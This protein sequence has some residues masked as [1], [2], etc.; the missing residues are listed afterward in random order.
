MI[1]TYKSLSF[2]K[3][4]GGT[5]MHFPRRVFMDIDVGVVIKVLD[6]VDPRLYFSVFEDG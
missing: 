6:L 1:Q 3:I 2:P 5:K 4:L